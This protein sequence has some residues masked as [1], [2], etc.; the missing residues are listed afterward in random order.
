MIGCPF[1]GYFLKY[2]LFNEL[3]AAEHFLLAYYFFLEK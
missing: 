3:N 1:L 2:V